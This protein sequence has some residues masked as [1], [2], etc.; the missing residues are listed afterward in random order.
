VDTAAGLGWIHK[1]N[2]SLRTQR[3]QSP[4]KKKY[5]KIITEYSYEDASGKLLFQVCRTEDK[6][7]P[8]RRPNGNG[9]WI[10]SLDGAPRVLYRLPELLAAGS[11]AWTFS[12][13]GE[14]DV[15]SLRGIGLTATCNPGGAGKFN[16]VENIAPLYGRRVAVIADADAA[17]RNHAQQ[18]AT[19]LY[20]KASEVRIFEMPDGAKDASEWIESKDSLTPEDLRQAFLE[21]AEAAPLWEPNSK[22]CQP[23]HIED[24]ATLDIVCLADV[25]PEEVEFLWFPYLPIGKI[26]FIDGDPSAGK[27]WL[28]LNIA[29]IVT[30]GDTFPN[31]KEF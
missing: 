25:E 13:E 16:L 30:R 8:V 22:D 1:L 26:T 14:K 12:P 4:A 5:G 15:E 24:L 17:G 29:A 18:V 10:W 9:G 2:P 19:A 11:E 20:G 31:E 23:S 6:E 3:C 27:T 21:M 28:A 7:F